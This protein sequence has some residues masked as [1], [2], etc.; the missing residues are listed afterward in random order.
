MFCCNR[1]TCCP[2]VFCKAQFRRAIALF[3]TLVRDASGAS[4]TSETLASPALARAW[5]VWLLLPCMLLFRPA[6]SPRVPHQLLSRFTAF[7]RGESDTLLRAALAEAGAAF[8]AP[9]RVMMF[10]R[11]AERAA[12][13]ARLG[14]LSAPLAP[15]SEAVLHELRD[16][17]R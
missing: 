3:L 2:P 10:Y 7:F 8:T 11:L 6:Q 9:R 1:A 5:K 12:H 15:A 16:P 13:L 17:V 4:P 14:E